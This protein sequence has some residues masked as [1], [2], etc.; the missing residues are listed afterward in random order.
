M[1]RCFFA[2][3]MVI[4]LGLGL[5]LSGGG[6]SANGIDRETLRSV[7][8]VLPVWPGQPQGGAAQ[9]P[10]AA[11]EGAG[12]VLRP[13]IVA[14][15]WHVVAPA[16]RVD[17]RL[18][19][20]RILPARM[21]GH[22]AASDIALLEV[23]AALPPFETLRD[24][25]LA[26]RACAIGNAFG[27]GLSVTCGVVSATGVSNAG[28]NPVEDFIQTDASANPG[29]S[30]GAL[31]DGE[32]RLIGMVSAIFASEGDTDIGITFAVSAALLERVADALITD[33][34]VR[35]PRPGWRLMPPDRTQSARLAAP[36]VT[37]LDAAGPAA[38][39]GVQEGDLL[40]EVNGRRVHTPRDVIAALAVLPQDAPAV[41]VLLERDRQPSPVEVALQPPEAA[42]DAQEQ[43]AVGAPDPACPYD[44]DICEIRQAV[45]PVSSFDPIASATRISADLL[46]TN[47]HVVGDFETAEIYTPDG[48][49]TARVVPSAYRGDLVLLQADGLPDEGLLPRLSPAM[50][51]PPFQAIGADIARQEIRVFAP[52]DLLAEPDPDA[53]LGRL[54]VTARMQPGVS[55]GALVDATGGM[56]AIAVGGGDGRFEAVPA[57]Q[58][59]PLLALREAPEA[60][61]V[62]QELGAA[63]ATCSGAIDEGASPEQT[64]QAC[65]AAENHGLLLEAG[66]VVS[67]AGDFDGAIALHSDAVAQ[68]PNSINARISLL[69]SLQLGARFEEMLPH[70]RWLLA[71]APQ[72]S[73]SLRFAIQA[74]VWGGDL[75]LAEAG[76]AQLLKTDPAQAQ[77]ARRFIDSPPPTPVRR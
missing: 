25:A 42:P 72:D 44:A 33:G 53:P 76:Y 7:V 35:Y 3:V 49:V 54:H 45:F 51:V 8:S 17:V 56:V 68:V 70:A 27:L 46:V 69:V 65:R 50:S 15:A 24:P 34:A 64:V 43:A 48:P 18:S 23:A 20:G 67:Q 14:T 77:A 61:G 52:G 5:G 55:G 75:E 57:A 60:T 36:V 73:N 59:L 30:G 13:G 9:P 19:D 11:P 40:I 74:G 2:L 62:T 71:A 58:V 22:D 38:L 39:A 1:Q 63:F 47:R 10:G 41:S 31:V 32:G 26:S 29:T 21:L 16:E 12:V 6:A 37:A 4:G 66:R 28:F